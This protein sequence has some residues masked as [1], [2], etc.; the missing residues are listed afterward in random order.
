MSLLKG[1]IEGD[2]LV[3]DEVN[4]LAGADVSVELAGILMSEPKAQ[5]AAPRV[6]NHEDFWAIEAFTEVIDDRE[7]IL[8]HLGNFECAALELEVV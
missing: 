4:D 3:L 7:G 8:L 6:S 1:V 5:N 2:L